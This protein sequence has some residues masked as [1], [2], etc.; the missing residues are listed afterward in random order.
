MFQA[1]NYTMLS[2]DIFLNYEL[3]ALADLPAAFAAYYSLQR[4]GRTYTLAGCQVKNT[5]SGYPILDFSI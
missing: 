2:G 3:T 5:Y 4:F 1:F